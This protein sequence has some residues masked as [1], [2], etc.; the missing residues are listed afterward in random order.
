MRKTMRK[1]WFYSEGVIMSRDYY[2]HKRQNGFYYVEFID[3]VT[4]KK[5]SARSTG[6]KDKIKAQ[7][8]AELWKVNGIP[9]GR[10][11]KPRPILK[12]AGIEAILRAI[13][14][15]E[16]DSDDALRIVSK[17]KSM[18]YIDIVAVK[19]TGRGLFLLFSFLKP[20]GT[21]INRHT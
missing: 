17:L 2:I 16:L 8:Q 19:N 3:K 20:F 5:L 10:L 9:I 4:G 21:T 12:V 6:E 18:G 13:S 15:T 14:K 11:K 7:I 1:S